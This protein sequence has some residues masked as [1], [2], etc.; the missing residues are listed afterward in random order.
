MEINNEFV[1][2]EFNDGETYA[3]NN[4]KI[5]YKPCQMLQ[6]WLGTQKINGHWDFNGT[7]YKFTQKEA[8][9]V[10]YRKPEYI[11]TFK[12]NIPT[13]FFSET[14]F[15]GKIGF[16][17]ISHNSGTLDSVAIGTLK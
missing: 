4:A 1:Y 2:A 16:M 5:E 13:K 10:E 17:M 3:L 11:L 8:R 7:P 12:N 9:V 15:V 6:F 14:F